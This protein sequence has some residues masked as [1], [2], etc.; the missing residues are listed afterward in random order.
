MK[1]ILIQ[2]KNHT[3]HQFLW[4]LNFFVRFFFFFVKKQE[5]MSM[6]KNVMKHMEF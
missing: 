3:I 6:E 1:G 5:Q 4:H 2:M